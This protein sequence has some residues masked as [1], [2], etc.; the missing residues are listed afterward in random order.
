M[1]DHP[2]KKIP[3]PIILGLCAAG[4]LFGFAGKRLT[5]APRP[6]AVGTAGTAAAK[7]T[8][9]AEGESTSAAPSSKSTKPVAPRL[10]TLHSTDTLESLAAL[11]GDALY[12]RLALWL[13]DAIVDASNAQ[14]PV[15]TV[16]PGE[17]V[18]EAGEPG[19]EVGDAGVVGGA[20]VGGAIIDSHT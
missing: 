15:C 19:F 7:T 2:V 5:S 10:S 12:A 16:F 20:F 3:F 9:V 18:A 8:A 14:E 1:K 6:A 17:D 11:K 4:F 13:L